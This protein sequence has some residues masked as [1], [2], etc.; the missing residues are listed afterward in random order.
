[1][2]IYDVL[3]SV[4]CINMLSQTVISLLSSQKVKEYCLQKNIVS[5]WL[6]GSVA[7]DTAH[8]DS[9][10]DIVYTKNNDTFWLFDKYDIQDFLESLLHKSVDM[11]SL[12]WLTEPIK[13]SIL[14]KYIKIF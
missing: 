6:T 1:M 13:S 14:S 10:V 4:S 7:E 3:L 2:G 12:V 11:I 5:L 9:D 8:T